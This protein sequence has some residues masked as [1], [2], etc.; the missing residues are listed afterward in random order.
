MTDAAVSLAGDLFVLSNGTQILFKADI[1]TG[2]L[3]L[4]GKI[5]TSIYVNSIAFSPFGKLFG[6]GHSLYQISP[7]DGSVIDNIMDLNMFITA[8]MPGKVDGSESVR[9][10]DD[11][12]TRAIYSVN[13]KTLKVTTEFLLNN[14]EIRSI[15]PERSSVLLK[16]AFL[17]A[18]MK[19]PP[20]RLK[21]EAEV[22]EIKQKLASSSK[23]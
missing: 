11:Y 15:I 23:S 5:D 21:T 7:A 2:K 18:A 9:M 8:L 19:Y 16:R 10:M 12:P 17:K 4:A 6:G 3:S 20:A 13:V 22:R 14:D 1:S